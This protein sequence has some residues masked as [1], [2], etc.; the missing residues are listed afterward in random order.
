MRSAP[1]LEE[2]KLSSLFEQAPAN[3][4]EELLDSEIEG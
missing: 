2:T 1:I 4:E 3:L